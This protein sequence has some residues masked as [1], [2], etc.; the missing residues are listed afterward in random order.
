MEEIASLSFFE[1]ELWDLT[2]PSEGV[3]ATLMYR[4]IQGTSLE[5]LH[6][7]R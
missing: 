5:L 6:A 3:D 2:G 7:K 4:L 1:I